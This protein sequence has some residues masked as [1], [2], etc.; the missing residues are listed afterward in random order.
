T[1]RRRRPPTSTRRATTRGGPCAP[2]SRRRARSGPAR[3]PAGAT[4]ASRARARSAR[5][6]RVRRGQRLGSPASPRGQRQRD[7]RAED[8]GAAAE[9]G[10]RQRLVQ[11]EVGED[12]RDERLDG[13]EERGGAGAD[14]LDGPV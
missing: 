6:S 2:G 9:L 3:A 1:G 7:D 14:E 4:P 11:D 13:G 12:D 10:R 5:R 8:Q